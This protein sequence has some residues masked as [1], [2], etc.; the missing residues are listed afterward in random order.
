MNA[1][2]AIEFFLAGASAIQ[3][4]TAN[5]VNPAVSIEIVSGI[6]NYLDKHGFGSIDDIIGGLKNWYKL[7]IS[8]I[9]KVFLFLL[10]YLLF[11]LSI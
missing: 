11:L 9:I 6:K 2:D 8:F 4:G 3:I 1:D 10:T 5:F 7:G